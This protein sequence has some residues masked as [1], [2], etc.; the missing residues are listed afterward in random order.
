MPLQRPK[1]DGLQAKC[2]RL[3]DSTHHNPQADIGEDP[4]PDDDYFYL[5]SRND[6][7]CQTL[8]WFEVLT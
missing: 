1:G 8:L 3:E 7:G 4:H 5:H 2:R 6:F